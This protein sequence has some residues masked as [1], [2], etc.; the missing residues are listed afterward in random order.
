MIFPTGEH[1]ILATRVSAIGPINV[2]NVRVVDVKSLFAFGT[3][4]FASNAFVAAAA[5]SACNQ[6][7]ISVI[8]SKVG[9]AGNRA[10]STYGNVRGPTAAASTAIG[11]I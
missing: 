9:T 6:E 10:Y 11:S 5:T 2:P 8:G 4:T 3:A 7:Q 1:S